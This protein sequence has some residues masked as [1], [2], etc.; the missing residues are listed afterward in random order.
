[1]VLESKLDIAQA[2]NVAHRPL[3]TQL[4]VFIMFHKKALLLTPRI[5]FQQRNLKMN[6]ATSTRPDGCGCMS[7]IPDLHLMS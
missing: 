7:I 5:L 6:N 1:M 2:G 4:P 3:V